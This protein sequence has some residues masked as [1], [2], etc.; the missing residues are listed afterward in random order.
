VNV[1][2]RTHARALIGFTVFL[3]AC[4]NLPDAYGPPE[5][6][7]LIPDDRPYRIHRVMNMSDADA[8]SRFVR[9]IS[10]GLAESWRWTGQRPAI[11]VFMRANDGVRYLIDFA[12]PEVTFKDT[13]PVTISFLVNDHLVDQVRYTEAGSQHFEK[14]VPAEWVPAGRE[15]TVAAEID[16]VW[17][18]PRD[19]AKLGFILIR[20]GLTQR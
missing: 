8:P 7:R 17:V 12:L 6:R 9:D 18:D 5:Q 19:G 3:S 4:Q 14:P 11:H 13:G 15:S 2:I 20:M 16:K 10:L 1:S